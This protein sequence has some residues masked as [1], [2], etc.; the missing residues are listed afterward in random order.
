MQLSTMVKDG[1]SKN[2]I[3]YPFKYLLP[4]DTLIQVRVRATNSAGPADWSP[5]MTIGA[6]IRGKPSQ[7]DKPT[8]LSKSNTNGAN[9]EN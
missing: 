3:D 7:V 9:A 1:A 6:R 5:L 4:Y 8:R 2:Q